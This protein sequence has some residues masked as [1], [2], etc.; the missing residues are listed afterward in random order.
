MY[1]KAEL[2][3]LG[4]LKVIGH[5]APFRTLKTDTKISASQHRSFFHSFIEQMHSVKEDFIPYPST[6][7]EYNIVMNRYDENYLPGCGGSV[8]VVHVKWSKCPA[9]DYNH[10]KGKDGYPSIA[11]EV[12]MGYDHQVLGVSSHFR[13]RNDQQI[14]RIDETVSLIKKGWYRNVKWTLHDKRG[15][16]RSDYGVYLNCDGG[17]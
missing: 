6:Q 4:V 3:I 1:V 2:L 12:I 8:D 11:F 10:C 9:G 13:I 16:K 5:H 14:V 7:D 15:E 17:T